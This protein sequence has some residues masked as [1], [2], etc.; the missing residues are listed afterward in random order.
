VSGKFHS[1][2]SNNSDVTKSVKRETN[3]FIH[4]KLGTFNLLMLEN[5][6]LNSR[7]QNIK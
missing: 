6:K 4:A 5:L 3:S 1:R 2:V 7:F